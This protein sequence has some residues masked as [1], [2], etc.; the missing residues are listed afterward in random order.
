M[1]K[2]VFW[3]AGGDR[4]IGELRLDGGII[5]A[6]GAARDVLGSAR[7]RGVPDGTTYTQYSDWS[8]GV[9]CSREVDA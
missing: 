9:F 1:R 3:R 4:V 6:T 8:N 7:A 2:V 5:V